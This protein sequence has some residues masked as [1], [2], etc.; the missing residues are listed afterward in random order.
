MKK[1]ILVRGPALSQSGYGEHARMILRALKEREDLFD[2]F[3]VPTGWGHT[4]WLTT[5]DSFRAWIDQKI[6]VTQAAIQQRVAFDLSIQVSIPNEFE[7]L[8]PINIGVTAGI[9][10]TKISPAWI[11]KINEMDKILVPSKFSKD[12]MQKTVYQGVNQY[13]NQITL[14]TQTPIEVIPYPI[15]DEIEASSDFT[16]LNLSE[17]DFAYLMVGQWG[18]RKNMEN[19]VGWWLEENW[20]QDVVLVVKTS[21]RRNNIMDREFTENRLKT[22]LRSVKL[23]AKKRKCSLRLLHGDMSEAEMKALYLHPAIKCMVTATHGEGFGLPMFEF[24]QTGKP[25]VA[26]GWSAHL[27]F[28]TIENIKKETTNAFL[29]VDYTLQPIQKEAVWDGVLQ[30]DS[31]WAFPD[32][33]SFKQRTR[34]VRTKWKKWIERSA[35]LAEY[36]KV[37]FNQQKINEALNKVLSDF[38]H[39]RIEEDIFTFFDESNL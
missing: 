23:D 29:S 30:Q 17:D 16:A 24:A 26:T 18:P 39:E 7:R 27:E 9:E 21:H 15:R 25:I 5:N 14:T 10:T 19:A 6:L 34:Q 20:E 37:K 22:L 11:Q 33:N 1:K 31:M 2:V 38:L 32:Q 3:I 13:G 4:G 35:E 28:L 8:A 36:N 12:V